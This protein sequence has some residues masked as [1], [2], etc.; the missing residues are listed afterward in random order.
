MTIKPLTANVSGKQ[1][2]LTRLLISASAEYYSPGSG[3]AT[4]SDKKF[5]EYREDLTKLENEAGFAYEGSPNYTVGTAA[6]KL[7]KIKHEDEAL[8]LDKVKYAEREKLATWLGKEK[9]TVSW[10]MD[11]L[12]VVLTYDDGRLTTAATR[13][14]GVEGED[15]THNAVNIEGIPVTIPFKDHLVIRGE[16]IMTYSEFER[17]LATCEDGE[18]YKNPRNLAAATIRMQDPEEAKKRK[19]KFYAFT[20]FKTGSPETEPMTETG[21]FGFM[22][23]QGFNVVK[24]GFIDK[25]T[26]EDVISSWQAEIKANDFPT[27]GLVISYENY[28]YA[29]SLGNTIHHPRG[30][31]ALKWKDKTERTTIRDII[32]SVGKTGQI[33]PVAVFDPVELGAGST[34]TKASLHNI[35]QMQNM[36]LIDDEFK[37]IKVEINSPCDVYLANMIIPQVAAV[38]PGTE[39]VAI[40]DVC[41]VCGQKT[42]LRTNPENGVT[43][44]FCVNESCPARTA[45]MLENAFGRDGFDAKGLGPSQIRDLQETGLVTIYPAEFFALPHLTNGQI[46]EVL[47]NKDGWGEKSWKLIMDALEECRHTTLQRF[48]YALGIPL[49]GNDLSKKLSKYWKGDV[50]NFMAFY[51]TPDAVMLTEDMEGVGETKA[52][53]LAEWCVKTSSDPIAHRMLMSLI[54]Y[55]DFEKPEE[56]GDRLA[57]LTFVITGDVHHY[58]N[59]DEFK[60]YV[61]Q[62][63]GKVAG[64]VSKKTNYLVNNDAASQSSKNKAAKDLGIPI[65]T[66]DEFVEKFG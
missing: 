6:G 20:L 9:G 36:P 63:G 15:V 55:L 3:G 42:E 58:R 30:S 5:D 32:W 18:E 7:K 54:S 51:K 22:R 23:E 35:S 21:R 37:T 64:S 52:R 38:L 16:A 27:D 57:G 66:E 4:L 10:K 33:T 43:T 62:N 49:L 11:G 40:P 45:G 25:E 60:A 12:T 50:Q 13:G 34:V 14:T 1:A 31:I 56:T 2:D 47:K 48:L 41:P 24:Y 59:R 53:S 39:P 17:I 65:I 8:S 19:L 26:M 61:E 44:L 46:P 28:A 29:K